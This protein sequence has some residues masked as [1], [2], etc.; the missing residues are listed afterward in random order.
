VSP[1]DE[2]NLITHFMD[3]KRAKRTKGE[4]K[5]APVGITRRLSA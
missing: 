3:F 5:I 2:A 1:G 4:L